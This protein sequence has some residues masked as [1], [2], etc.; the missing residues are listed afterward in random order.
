MHTQIEINVSNDERKLFF[1]SFEWLKI[2][3]INYQNG[4]IKH[5]TPVWMKMMSAW[6]HRRP[7]PT[8][9]VH[10]WHAT[11]EI[12]SKNENDYVTL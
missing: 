7:K 9:F 10:Q 6:N 1:A 2:E 5:L 4:E 3:N 11:I 8:T 12:I